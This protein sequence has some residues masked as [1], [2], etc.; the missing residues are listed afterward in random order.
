MLIIQSTDNP[1]IK[2]IRLLLKSRKA[3]TLHGL[4]IL[5]NRN[6][7][8]DV[9]Q[10]APHLIQMLLST[11]AIETYK[12]VPAYEIPES[13][14]K[15]LSS[16]DTHQGMIAVI[17]KQSISFEAMLPTMH[18]AVLLDGISNPNNCG[19]IIR[20][21]VAFGMS[22]VFYT[23]KTVDFYHPQAVRSMA[24]NMFQIPFIEI[25]PDRIAQIHQAGFR[26]FL[27]EP[28]GSTPLSDIQFG[29]KNIFVFGS[30]A[31]GILNET[32]K[33]NAMSLQIEMN[34]NIDSLN[35]AVSSGILLH[36]YYMK[37]KQGD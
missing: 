13:M 1:K 19:A 28:R 29:S 11:T 3:R 31:D 36:Y 20:N 35:V 34:P 9:I 12:N 26:F 7:I 25:T 15:T 8:E 10:N 27:L 22:A 14:M 32:L 33:K 18:Q 17:K 21:A 6:A 5:E 37:S 30:A 2:L 16:L 4:F 24:G 23:P